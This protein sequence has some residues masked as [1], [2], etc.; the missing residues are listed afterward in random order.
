MRSIGLFIVIIGLFLPFT[1]E[2]WGFW[3]HRRVN[4]IAVFV[5]REPLLKF[6]KTYI[7]YVTEEATKPD[8]RRFVIEEEA[9]KHYIDIDHYGE[10]PFENVP[11]KWDEA[12]KK[13][14]KDTLMA[15]GILPWAIE[16]VY[17][18]L[19]GAF[20]EKNVKKILKI[21]ADLG[22]YVADAHV[23]LH[24]TENYNGQLTG[25]K[26]IHALWESRIPELVGDY[27]DYFIGRAYYIKDPLNEA[28]SAVLESHLL[29]DSV[30]RVEKKLTQEFG[31]DKKYS[32]EKRGNTNVK[33]YSREFAIAYYNALNGMQEARMRK[34]ILRTASFWYSAWIDGGKPSV[35]ELLQQKPTLEYEK[36][37]KK[38]K[39]EDREARIRLPDNTLVINEVPFHTNDYKYHLCGVF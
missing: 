19:V 35:D 2:G 3:A 32:Y 8:E 29:V 10:Y 39:I 1:F 5:V 24:T 4:R 28:W 16:K 12:V 37:I 38:L 21:S 15:Y 36:I 25:Q 7:D 18:Q 17:Y 9:P 34:S 23:P 33:V 31:P 11:R 20:K 22:H 13:F 14:S 6:Y 30:L 26:G 27:F